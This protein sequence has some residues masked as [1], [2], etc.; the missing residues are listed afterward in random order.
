M[1]G[2][3][4]RS[5][6]RNT[7]PHLRQI[8]IERLSSRRPQLL[9]LRFRRPGSLTEPGIPALTMEHRQRS[10]RFAALAAV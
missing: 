2:S 10:I 7:R 5:A 8:L 3:I 6:G 9:L 4:Y 1:N